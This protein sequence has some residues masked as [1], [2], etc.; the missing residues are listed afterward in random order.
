MPSMSSHGSVYSEESLTR[1]SSKSVLSFSHLSYQVA[2]K[3]GMK[4][5]VDDVSVEIR[6]GEL[7]AVMVRSP[8]FRRR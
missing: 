6:A 7:L 2:T 4:K 1:N 8:I 5:M 3:D